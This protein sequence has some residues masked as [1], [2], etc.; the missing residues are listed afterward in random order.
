M[1]DPNL[2]VVCIASF[3]AVLLILSILAVVMHFLLIIFP[4]KH[5]VEE[6][7]AIIAAI[8]ATFNRQFP[9]TRI[10]NIGEEK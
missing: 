10:T 6:D 5:K 7:T 9:G 2:L 8:T 1:N 3:T 4:V